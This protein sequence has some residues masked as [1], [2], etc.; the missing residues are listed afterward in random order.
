MEQRLHSGSSSYR[1]LDVLCLTGGSTAWA[2]QT[3]AN[4]HGY[5]SISQS[6]TSPKHIPSALTVYGST[7]LLATSN[8]NEE[9][10]KPS[11]LI[12]QDL[13][14]QDDDDVD[15]TT[16]GSAFYDIDYIDDNEDGEEAKTNEEDDLEDLKEFT[17][18]KVD[19]DAFDTTTAAT[20]AA[21]AASL[22]IEQIRT[23]SRH[24]SMSK[25]GCSASPSA[26]GSPKPKFPRV[27]QYASLV[28][29]SEMVHRDNSSFLRTF[30]GYQSLVLTRP[31][32]LGKT[33]LFSLVELV[34]SK[35]ER[36]PDGLAYQPPAGLKTRA[37]F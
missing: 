36:C 5:G 20:E 33:T 12:P 24:D 13:F 22:S 26:Q 23:V 32:Q 6:S 28:Y 14:N 7:R 3:Q 1:F 21:T 2:F 30:M 4:Q 11:P 37:L 29:K 35:N 15:D 18:D 25:R 10:S 17:R 34:F 27:Q 16:E 31:M 9:P 8:L 19:L